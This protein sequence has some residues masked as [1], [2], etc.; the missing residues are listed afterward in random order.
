CAP[1]EFDKIIHAAE[2]ALTGAFHAGAI[3]AA[4]VEHADDFG[5]GILLVT[6]R[7]DHFRA[8]V[9]AADDDSAARQAAFARPAPDQKKQRSAKPDQCDET[10]CVKAREPDAREVF[11][12]F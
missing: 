6:Q 8:G 1:A 7:I 3:V 12:G 11:A 4:V 2:F 5:A 9:A 10:A